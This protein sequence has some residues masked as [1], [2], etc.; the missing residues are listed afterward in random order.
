MLD[1]GRLAT[2]SLKGSLTVLVIALVK[3]IWGSVGNGMAYEPI[4]TS[5]STQRRVKVY[6]NL[7]LD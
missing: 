5:L 1:E 7:N 2:Q 6:T 4:I 3:A